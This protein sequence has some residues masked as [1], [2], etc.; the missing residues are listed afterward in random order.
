MKSG[1]I[2]SL[3]MYVY[4]LIHSIL[5]EDW[6]VKFTQEIGEKWVLAPFHAKIRGKERQ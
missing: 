4:S 1:L 5:R 2:H 6:N 3:N